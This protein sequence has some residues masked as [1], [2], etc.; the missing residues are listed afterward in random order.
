MTLP[1]FMTLS[2]TALLAAA[3]MA[4]SS[5]TGRW[6]P[7][8]TTPAGDKRET[9]FFL[10]QDGNSLTGAILNGYRMQNIAAG[11][12]EGNEASWTVVMRGGGP[13]RRIEYH[14]KLAGDLLT[15]T[16]PAFGRNAPPRDVSAKKISS[17]GT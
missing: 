6:P 1:R 16:M 12:V 10:K 8:T 4:P 15:V 2:A 7:E 9:T 13:E 17:E 14:A 11:K 3:P 5:F